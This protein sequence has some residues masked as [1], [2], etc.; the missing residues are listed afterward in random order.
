[1]DSNALTVMLLDKRG[2]QIA[3]AGDASLLDGN[4]VRSFCESSS[5]TVADLVANKEFAGQLHQTANTHLHVSLVGH[6]AILAV[7]FDN[8][9]SLGLVRLRVKKAS[10]QLSRMLSEDPTGSGGPAPTSAPSGSS[11][12]PAPAQ[13]ADVDKPL[14]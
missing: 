2:E 12:S 10:E 7:L 3:M 1:R 9:S 4:A 6:R 13:I 8:R 14:N 11:G 5:R